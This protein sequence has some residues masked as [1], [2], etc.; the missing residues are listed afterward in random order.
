MTVEKLIEI[1]SKFPGNSVV[2]METNHCQDMTLS[3][4]FNNGESCMEVWND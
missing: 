2:Q 1:L 3:V 4:Y